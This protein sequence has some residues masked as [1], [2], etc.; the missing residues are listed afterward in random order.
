MGKLSILCYTP[1][2]SQTAQIQ[3]SKGGANI[4]EPLKLE[5]CGQCF[6]HVNKK[7]KKVMPPSHFQ[8][9]GGESRPAE[10]L[11]IVVGSGRQQTVKKS[12]SDK[13][14][15]DD[16]ALG[17]TVLVRIQTAMVH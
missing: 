7:K 14:E 9:P 17:P 6:G 5:M 2:K 11:W 1:H 8:H 12:G 10:P 4:A 13:G 3:A 16:P 15:M